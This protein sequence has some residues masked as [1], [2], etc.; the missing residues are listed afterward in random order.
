MREVDPEVDEDIAAKMGIGPDEE[1]PPAPP[2]LSGEFEK[3][4]IEVAAAFGDGGLGYTVAEREAWIKK[5]F[6]VEGLKELK[7]EELKKVLAIV[8]KKLQERNNLELKGV[9]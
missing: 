4:R 7:K 6:K 3:L 9:A 5:Y 2:R 1:E 8:R